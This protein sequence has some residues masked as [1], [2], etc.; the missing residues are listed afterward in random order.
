ME[1]RR[2][3]TR[4]GIDRCFSSACRSRQWS[5]VDVRISLPGMQYCVCRVYGV[6]VCCVADAGAGAGLACKRVAGS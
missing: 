1:Q 4:D 2:K 5:G 3:M 6:G